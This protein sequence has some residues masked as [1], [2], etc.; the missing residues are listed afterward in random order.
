MEND[1]D[2]MADVDDKTPPE[3]VLKML[4][5]ARRGYLHKIEQ[6][7][8]LSNENALLKI[9]LF[10]SSS[11]KVQKQPDL[12]LF[13]EAK[14][15]PQEVEEDAPMVAET[16][17]LDSALNDVVTPQKEKKK[18]GRKPIPACYQRRDIIH[19]LPEHQKRC[20][21]GCALSKIGE[22]VSEQLDVIPAQIYVK[23]HIRFKYACKTCQ[24]NVKIASVQH[25]AILKTMAAP[26]LLAHVAV[27]KFDDHLPLYRQ[28]EIWARLGVEISR[29]TLSSWILKMGI[30]A[31]PLVRYLQ[32][33]LIQSGYVKADETVCQVLKTPGKSDKTNSYMW[34]YMTG[35]NPRPAVVYEYQESRKGGFAKEFLKGVQGVLQSDGYSGYNCVTEQEGVISQGCFAH[36][37]RKFHDVWKVAKKEGIASKAMEVIGKLYDIECQIKDLSS[38]EK[39]NIRAIQAKPILD[40]FH[41]WLLEIKPH[42]QARGL[43]DKAIQYTLNQWE[44]LTYY[45]QNGAVSIDNNAAERQIKPFAVGRK[46]WLFMGSPDG[47]K[48]A[49]NLYSLIETAKLNDVNPEGYLKFLMEH[50][51]DANDTALMEK[52]MPWNANLDNGYIKPSLT[53]KDSEKNLDP[54]LKTTLETIKIH[55][56][57]S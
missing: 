42:V 41:G 21:C 43:L 28:S 50:T 34:V 16:S 2:F 9:K 22:D 36:A 45:V 29:A 56:N 8:I 46:N 18:K 30:A 53:P 33:H 14:A 57:T 15:T 44:S 7:A 35:N 37:R 12:Q 11:E 5:A 54:N 17:T 23:R 1:I 13:D 49:A 3:L 24:E 6:Y 48:A 20:S 39:R 32:N 51:I 52:L 38:E 31:A 26:G 10:G 47:A 19:D 27:M 4:H 25:Q 55:N 40:A